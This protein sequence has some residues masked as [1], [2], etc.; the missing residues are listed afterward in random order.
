MLANA[1]HIC[2]LCKFVT[3]P[4]IKNIFII[5]QLLKLVHS[6]LYEYGTWII[7]Q[8]LMLKYHLAVTNYWQPYQ[9]SLQYRSPFW[10]VQDHHPPVRI[11]TNLK[12]IN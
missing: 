7:K 10:T 6:Q 2:N 8:Y 1:V 12:S 5:P 11:E 4:Q 9:W 3:I